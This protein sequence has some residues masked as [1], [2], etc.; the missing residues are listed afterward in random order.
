MSAPDGS[1][2]F[3]DLDVDVD[4][5]GR[6][7]DMIWRTGESVLIL[8]ALPSLPLSSYLLTPLSLTV[9]LLVTRADVAFMEVGADSRKSECG[10]MDE[11]PWESRSLAFPLCSADEEGNGRKEGAD[12]SGGGGEVALRW[13][14]NNVDAC[15]L[16]REAIDS[17]DVEAMRQLSVAARLRP[18]LDMISNA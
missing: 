15:E 3:G 13:D 2:T 18:W 10:A 5:V 14:G 4:A 12:D 8:F 1:C 6:S 17:A 9:S 11:E 7:L 16:L